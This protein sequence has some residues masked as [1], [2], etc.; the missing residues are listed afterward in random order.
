MQ[1]QQGYLRKRTR[2]GLGLIAV[3]ALTLPATASAVRGAGQATA[4]PQVQ[5]ADRDGGNKKDGLNDAGVDAIK[6]IGKDTG[7]GGKFSIF[8]AG[9]AEQIN[10]Q[11]T[12]TN[13]ARYRAVIFLDTG[14]NVLNDAQQEA[15]ESYFHDGG[16]FVGIGS[17]IETEPGWQFFTDI[18]GARAT[19]KTDAQSATIKVADRVH[20]AS[21]NLPEYWNRTDAWYN[22]TPT[23]AASRTC[24]RRWSRIRSASSRRARSRRDRR[25]HDGRRPSGRLVQGLQGRPL[26][27]HRARKHRGELRRGA[28]GATSK[29]R[30]TGPPAWPTRPTATAARPCSRTTSR[31]R[32]AARRT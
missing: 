12:E 8:V 29:A 32:S 20:D 1:P 17:A 5:G 23:S 26:V 27:L 30:S 28:F 31:S 11:F 4:A 2:L 19:G 24:S 7:T 3:A 10:D 14:A 18:L 21:K 15:F 22:F 16:G 6:A 13:L 9:N 25:R